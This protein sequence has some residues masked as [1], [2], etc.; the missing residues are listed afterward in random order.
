VFRLLVFANVVTSSPILVTLMM[1]RI[2]FSETSI[3]TRAKRRSIPEDGILHSDRRENLKSYYHYCDE[4]KWWF[5]MMAIA[6][7]SETSATTW[8]SDT[9]QTASRYRCVESGLQGCDAVLLTLFL[10]HRFFPSCCWRLYAP[11]KRR[12]LQETHDIS[13]DAILERLACDKPQILDVML[14]W[15]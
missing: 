9:S 1:E 7:K 4:Q 14:D 13:E 6:I 12:L 2:L 11:Q 15:T 10:A 3:R 5:Y 8:Q